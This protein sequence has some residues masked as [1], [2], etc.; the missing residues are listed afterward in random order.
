[1]NT[2]K[3]RRQKDTLKVKSLKDYNTCQIFMVMVTTF[4][5][6]NIILLIA[7]D[8]LFFSYFS[9]AFP[10]YF[11]YLF[12]EFCGFMPASFYEKYYTIPIIVYVNAKYYYTAIAISVVFV[13][14]LVVATIFFR[15]HRAFLYLSFGLYILDT[16][17]YLA[18]A[19][20][21]YGFTPDIIITTFVHIIVIIFHIEAICA[22]ARFRR[23][24]LDNE[25]ECDIAA[26]K[27]ELE[28]ATA[29]AATAETATVDNT[30]PENDSSRGEESGDGEKPNEEISK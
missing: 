8:S 6:F 21:F 20:R 9:T 4:T 30:V 11:T 27:A 13:L 12:K 16:I 1:M 15:K 26:A 28:L 17:G 25:W 5:V 14:L 10:Y 19:F 23:Y 24:G 22:E 7:S 2:K 29:E 18:I 3:K